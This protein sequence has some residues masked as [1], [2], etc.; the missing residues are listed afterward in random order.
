MAMAASAMMESLF[1]RTLDDLVK[2]LRLQ[3]IG[4]SR[5]MAKALEEVRKEMKSTDPVIK[6]AAL[7]KLTYLQMACGADMS[8]ASFHIVEVMTMPKF[9][10]KKVGYLAAAQ[11]FYEGTDVLVLTTN[12]LRKDMGSKNEYETSL[13]I[14]C[15]SRILNA[16]LA[17][18]LTP[19]VFTLMASSRS[20]LRKKAT[21]VLL[22][23]FVR[24]PD[25][26]R[27]AF[28][29]L[30]E[31]MDDADPQVVCAAVSV[32]CELTLKDPR[33]YL[34]LA[35]EFYRLFEKSTNNWL[36][37]KLVKIFGVLTPLEPRLARKIAGPLCDHMRKTHA[38]SL[39]FECIRTV[40]LGLIEHEGAVKLC[41]DKLR[42]NMALGDPNLKYLGLK[43]LAALMDAHPWALESSKEVIIKCLNDGDLSIQRSALVLIMGMVS[44]SNVE[45]TVQVRI[46]QI[47][48][49]FL[50]ERG[51]HC[52]S[53]M[54]LFC[55]IDQCFYA[56][57]YR[58]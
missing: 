16:D 27:V 46:T 19:E 51:I 57:S 11:S 7:Q 52:A 38:K 12:L 33:A 41:V 6:V 26:I 43:A 49:G 48:G 40:T 54:K 30:V 24:F 45:E 13:A 4:E 18:A 3:M 25:A 23:V 17:G 42:E 28:K 50:L 21:L 47:I 37:I 31:K 20:F 22:R 34:P 58:V 10:H 32:L 15:L 9:A 5:Y 53:L 29:R 39:L 44:E 2:G 36:S 56:D 35:P 55:A 14:D 1:Q 8:W